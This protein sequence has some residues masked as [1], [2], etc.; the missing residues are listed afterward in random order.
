MVLH[1]FLRNF[2]GAIP[3]SPWM[4]GP[5]VALL[6]L[7]ILLPIKKTA[8]ARTRNYLGRIRWAWTEILID[9]LSPTL[10]LIVLA[11]AIALAV[12]I[13]P[14]NSRGAHGLF[15]ILVATVVLALM[16]FADRISRGVL[17]RIAVRSPALQG[18][19]GLIQSVTRGVVIG[20]AL[21]VFLDSV[22]ISITPLI[23]SLGIG[24]AA[25]ALALQDTLANLFAGIYMMAEK[26]IQAGHFIQLESSEQG[27][28]EKV[29]WR[30][31]Q[32]RMLSD[33]MIVVPNSKLADSV[34]TNFSLPRDELAFTL[35]I[36]VDYGSDLEKVELTTLEVACEV[37][38]S[39]AGAL[40]EFE[41]RVRY[42]A[43]AD[44]SINFR[45]W[46][47]AK[48]YLASLSVKHEFIK[49]LH[50]RYLQEGITI[51][52]PIRTIDLPDSTVSKLREAFCAAAW[53]SNHPSTA[54]KL[55]ED[56]ERQIVPA[57]SA[58]R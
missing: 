53:G 37:I 12:W 54:V 22:G 25:V 6:W 14:L 16:V 42:T 7:V 19:L 55:G 9:A 10:T 49:R 20:L 45:V 27:W 40:P 38:K 2:V 57:R 17:A 21:M 51:P 23:A 4:V 28:V 18:G 47:A 36:G 29:G 44:S 58:P 24:T 13:L 31:T 8:L 39:I 32:I 43:F 3:L 56:A 26:P 50:A 5:V 33:T 52:F 46:L 34:I 11:G 48:D 15:I 1:S 41:P 30:S 35:D